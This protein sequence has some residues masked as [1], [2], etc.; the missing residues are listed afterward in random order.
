MFKPVSI[1]L[2]A[3]MAFCASVPGWADDRDRCA[4]KQVE[5]CTRLIDSANYDQEKGA[6]FRK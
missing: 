3:V 5:A 1:T 4:D 6:P 2:G